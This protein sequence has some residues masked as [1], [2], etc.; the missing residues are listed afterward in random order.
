[1]KTC[2]TLKSLNIHVTESWAPSLMTTSDNLLSQRAW[3]GT[4]NYLTGNFHWCSW[5]SARRWGHENLE[6]H[7]FLYM[8]SHCTGTFYLW[9]FD[10]LNSYREHESFV[11][12]FSQGK[13]CLTKEN[14]FFEHCRLN[15][16]ER[17]SAQEK[18]TEREQ[19]SQFLILV[20]SSTPFTNFKSR[21]VL[22]SQKK[23]HSIP[24]VPDRA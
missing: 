8:M 16:N 23:S 7:P 13:Y 22:E 5:M 18:E 21:M 24:L 4:G 12:K 15:K 2:V 9:C 6:R 17:E 20:L 19:E 14:W 11:E 10:F 1:M 3:R